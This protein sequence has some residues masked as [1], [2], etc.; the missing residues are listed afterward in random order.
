MEVG[1]AT[2]ARREAAASVAVVAIIAIVATIPYYSYDSYDSYY[3]YYSY[4]GY[5]F[6]RLDGPPGVSSPRLG[7][8]GFEGPASTGRAQHPISLLGIS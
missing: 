4:Y 8:R 1:G 2:P 3:S 7:G 5:C 6:G